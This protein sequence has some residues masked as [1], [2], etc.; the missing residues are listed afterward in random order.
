M[1]TVYIWLSV[2]LYVKHRSNVFEKRDT[3]PG[4]RVLELFIVLPGG[5]A[6]WSHFGTGAPGFG[7]LQGPGRLVGIG[8][9]S[10]GW[11]TGMVVSALVAGLGCPIVSMCGQTCKLH[12]KLN[13][14]YP[15]SQIWDNLLFGHGMWHKEVLSFINLWYLNY[16]DRLWNLGVVGLATSP[17]LL[18]WGLS[19]WRSPVQS[20]TGSPAR[21]PFQFS[22]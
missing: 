3:P 11:G 20:V 9:M 14:M 18:H 5:R 4:G 19:I 22:V 21:R 7:N 8:G 6:S 13:I 17:S 1:K 16:P 15:L 12:C 10:S 2:N